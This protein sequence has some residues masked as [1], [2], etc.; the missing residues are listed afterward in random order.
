V[1]LGGAAKGPGTPVLEMTALMAPAL[2]F[3]LHS[4]VTR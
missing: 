1:S 2:P 3:S 4:R